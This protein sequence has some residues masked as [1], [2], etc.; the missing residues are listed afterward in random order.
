MAAYRGGGSP[1]RRPS[2]RSP[3]G[4][5]RRG[6]NVT[7]V[8][9]RLEGMIG[10]QTELAT[11]LVPN[12]PAVGFSSIRRALRLQTNWLETLARPGRAITGFTNILHSSDLPAWPRL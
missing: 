2:E 12:S 3:T 4:H 6:G 9:M 1:G 7:G 8:S 10:K 5:A 11:E